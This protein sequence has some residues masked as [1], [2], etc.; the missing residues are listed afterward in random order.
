MNLKNN[1]ALLACLFA[2][3]F[4]VQPVKGERP[5]APKLLPY[6]TVVYLRV[7][8]FPALGDDFQ[9]TS[10]GKIRNDATV[11]PLVDRLYN[12]FI[13]AFPQIEDELGVSVEELL[14]LPTGEVAISLAVTDTGRP[15]FAFIADVGD[16]VDTATTL[17]ERAEFEHIN[18]AGDL[19]QEM[20]GETEVTLFANPGDDDD[21]YSFIKEETVVLC[22][23]ELMAT[24][25]ISVWE[26]T[27]TE[28]D[29]TLADNRKFT[30]IMRN[31]VGAEDF[32]PQ[33]SFY[34]DPLT[35]IKS[36]TQDNFQAQ[37]A[38]AL[39]PT[40]GVDG[41]KAVGGSLIVGPPGFDT[42]AHF[43][44]S[45]GSPRRGVFN[46][47][48]L[49]EGE[50]S[51]EDWVS[52]DISNYGTM[53]WDLEKMYAELTTVVDS[54]LGGGAFENLVE[55]NV[56]TP[57][58]INLQEDVI[59]HLAGRL[60]FVQQ[61][62]DPDVLNGQATGL[63]FKLK[64]PEELTDFMD[65]FIGEKAA[66]MIKKSHN[67]VT[68]Y[69]TPAGPGGPPQQ[70][71]PGQPNTPQQRPG[72]GNFRRPTPTFA[73]IGDTFLLSDS[74]LIVFKA[75]DTHQGGEDRLTDAEDFKLIL[76]TVRSQ[77]GEF[78]PSAITFS[79][80]EKGLEF[81]YNLALGEDAQ[82]ALQQ[83]AENNDFLRTLNSAFLDHPLPPFEEISKY[84]APSGGVLFNRPTGLHFLSF[85]LNPENQ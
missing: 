18:N 72:A 37:A 43:H 51:A 23:S 81:I 49:G 40:L 50:L 68:Y 41:F 85:S 82:S 46:L 14:E 38:L 70:A 36:T 83:G 42:M 61:V 34:A 32:Q 80:P 58:G 45:L 33:I 6:N 2:L 60:T 62:V 10:M 74:E 79:R 55:E 57:A 3:I 26:G 25:L 77:T 30:D 7:N 44:L 73:I 20:I 19:S 8:D 15:M 66:W 39:L 56:N 24:H 54:V 84:M 67:G 69:Q 52:N 4:T 21:V 11:S 63:G 9:R 13:N 31:S 17:L 53:Y 12:E 29:R 71:A 64:E 59:A 76:D 47:L 48:T 5:S 22:S 65:S 28:L 27:A 1:S 16:N 75:I 78:K 35:L